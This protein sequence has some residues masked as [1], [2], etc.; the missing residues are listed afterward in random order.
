MHHLDGTSGDYHR[1]KARQA[2]P[3]PTPHA[4]QDLVQTEIKD[5]LDSGI[6]E[7]SSSERASPIVLWTRRTALYKS[8]STTGG[9]TWSHSWMHTVCQGLIT[10][11]TS[12]KAFQTL[13][14]PVHQSLK[15]CWCSL[16]AKGHHLELKK[17]Q[18]VV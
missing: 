8:L 1:H 14:D 3:I 9:L 7:P 4:Y 18:I 5:M 13:K 15:S 11:S 17:G 6:I 16:K 10:C 2:L 12:C